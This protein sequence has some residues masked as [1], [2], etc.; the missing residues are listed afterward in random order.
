[1]IEDHRLDADV[2][3]V[4]WMYWSTIQGLVELEIKFAEIDRVRA[5]E[6]RSTRDLVRS[7]TEIIVRGADDT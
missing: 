5:R 3:V 7:F 4:T 2:D 1:M 6:S